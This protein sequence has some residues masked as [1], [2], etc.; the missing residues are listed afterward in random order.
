MD[1]IVGE[2]E[3]DDM[4]MAADEDEVVVKGNYVR[5]LVA[6]GFEEILASGLLDDGFWQPSF[7]RSTMVHDLHTRNSVANRLV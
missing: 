6:N 5:L 1:L 7:A 3:D 2:P 4:L